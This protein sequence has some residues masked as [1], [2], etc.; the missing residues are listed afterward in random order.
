MAG[1][2][3]FVALVASGAFVL[4]RLAPGDAVTD[5]QLTISDP[6]VIA[7]AR[8]RLGLD[9][10]I[11]T[12]YVRWAKGLVHLDLGQSSRFGLPVATLVGDRLVNTAKL[13]GIALLTATLLGVPAGIYTGTRSRRLARSLLASASVALVACPPILA[14]IGLLLVAISTGWLSTTPGSL[15]LPVIALALP[16]AAVLE[17]LQSQ[18]SSQAALSPNVLAAAARGIPSSRLVWIHGARQSLRPVL[19]IFGIIVATLFSGSVAVE[20]ITAWP[21]LGRLMLDAVQGRDLFLVAGC[22][23]AGAMLIAIGNLI[24]DVVGAAIDPRLRES[25]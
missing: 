10:S 7:A 11:A 6:T 16:T 14:T 24:A 1:A 22:A 20:T 25:S 17:R 9:Q 5:M 23:M 2:V 18:S 8:T 15:A 3:V 12:Q 19:G 21:G 13:A 4:V